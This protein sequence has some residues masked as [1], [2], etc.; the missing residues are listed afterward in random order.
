MS[1]CCYIPFCTS[2][3]AS[4]GEGT[5][6]QGGGRCSHREREPSI[7][8]LERREVRLV[9][10]FQQ[11][12]G[13]RHFSLGREQRRRGGRGVGEQ[14]EAMVAFICV[15]GLRVCVDRVRL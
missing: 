11:G 10:D 9:T 14:N 5:R 8:V 1:C 4:V 13:F 6:E 7:E 2:L 3:A 12:V 15:S